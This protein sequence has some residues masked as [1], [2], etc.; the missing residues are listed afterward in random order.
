VKP[1]DRVVTLNGAPEL[2]VIAFADALGA[3]PGR[4][5]A[6][7]VEREGR[8]LVL[9]LP[10]REGR[11]ENAGIEFLFAVHLV[12][13]APWTQ[14][15]DQVAMTF[16]T[17]WALINPRSDIG[18]SKMS[19]PVGIVHIFHEAA[20]AG[21]RPIILFTILVNVNLAIFNLL[22]IP[23]LDGGQMLF[24]TIGRLRGRSLPV[25]FVMATQT[26]FAV[27]ILGVMLY[28]SV[29]DG[30]RWYREGQPVRSA[31]AAAPAEVPAATPAGAAPAPAPAPV[32]P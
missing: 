4:A 24:A 26:G 19:G 20:E 2:N 6:L 25:S 23:V 3:A 1:G 5:A 28:L 11:H 9:T 15:G 7:E 16:R 29:F 27:L 30:M 22:P 12:H 17:L 10:P 31:A 21:L 13:P 32:K 14:V 8:T 18:L